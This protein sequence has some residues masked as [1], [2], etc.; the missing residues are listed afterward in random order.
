MNDNFHQIMSE[1]TKKLTGNPKEDYA[2]LTG[3]MEKYKDH[4]LNKEI[5]R[6][7]GR[8]IADLVSDEAFQK[9]ILK[10]VQSYEALLEEVRMNMYQKEFGKAFQL[11]APIIQKTDQTKPF[12]DDTV[13]E[14]HD[15]NNLLEEVLYQ[16]V[17]NPHKDLRQTPFPFSELYGLYGMIL[18]E[19]QKLNEAETALKESLRW[20]PF[21]ALFRFE[22]IEI[23]KMKKD[24]DTFKKLTCE[25]F[26]YL[27]ERQFLAKAYRNLGYYF[28][29]NN[30]YTEASALY[31]YSLL[32]EQSDNARNELLYIY[33]SGH[34]P[35]KELS[36]EQLDDL[37][38]DFDF[39]L[40]PDETIVKAILFLG[41]EL[42]IDQQ[43]SSAREVLTIAYKLTEHKEIL[44]FIDK[45]PEMA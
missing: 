15:F 11:I 33:H 30:M 17:F 35:Q 19:L 44:D 18:I 42:Y 4:P 10:D 16:S 36:M 45:I 29:E 39:P 23:F 12:Q 40:Y 22:Y 13:S 5:I 26:Q 38:Y 41:H 25:S 3:E 9:A 1:I 8:M 20:N 43:Y 27:Y 7:I 21:N 34:K 24:Y 14:Y 32:F 37:A 2:Y 31:H 28:I 6:A